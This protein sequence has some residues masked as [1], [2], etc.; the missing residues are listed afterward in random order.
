MTRLHPNLEIRKGDRLKRRRTQANLPRHKSFGSRPETQLV[1][2]VVA[3]SRACVFASRGILRQ[4]E[5]A[6]DAAY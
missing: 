2:Q 4:S 5:N 3:S 1:L 6:I